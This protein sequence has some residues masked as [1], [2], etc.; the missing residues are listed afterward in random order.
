[1]AYYITISLLATVIARIKIRPCLF[2][3]LPII[4]D[5]ISPKRGQPR[6]GLCNKPLL[7]DKILCLE[8]LQFLTVAESLTLYRQSD[9]VQKR[10]NRDV[11]VSW[12]S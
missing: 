4:R 12:N 3:T 10:I 8:Q 11:A 2:S 9:I 5:D 7:I 6:A 1:M